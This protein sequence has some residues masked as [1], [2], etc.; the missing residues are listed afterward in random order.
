MNLQLDVYQFLEM[1]FV[2]QMIKVARVTAYVY[3]SAS[4]RRATTCC[5]HP[6]TQTNDHGDYRWDSFEVGKRLDNC[7]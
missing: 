1:A 2:E 3:V 6:M 4:T 7:S 5:S